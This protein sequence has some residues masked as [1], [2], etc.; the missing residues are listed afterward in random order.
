MLASF[1]CALKKHWVAHGKLLFR[2]SDNT[3]WG[4]PKS[5]VS[6][7]YRRVSA[8]GLRISCGENC[9]GVTGS[10]EAEGV[11][12]FGERKAQSQRPGK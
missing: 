6:I 1:L 12:V 9:P 3:H 11:D 2:L 10:R 4:Q 5:P 8:K 7:K